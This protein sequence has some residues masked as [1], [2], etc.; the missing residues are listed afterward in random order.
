MKEYENL[1][2]EKILKFADYVDKNGRPDIAIRA[3]NIFLNSSVNSFE[4]AK[5][6]I[7]IVNIYI[8][9]NELEKAEE[10]LLELYHNKDL[11]LK[12]N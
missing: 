4:N 11:Q 9:Q 7:R 5:T 8:A 12:K 10:I 3:Y 6:K 2:T 1:P